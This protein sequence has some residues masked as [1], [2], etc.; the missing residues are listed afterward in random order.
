MRPLGVVVGDPAAD[1][2]AG[3]VE[4]KKD[5]LVEELV[6]HPAVEAF[7]EA[8]LHRF[9]GR[10]VVPFDLMIDCPAEDRVRGELGAVVADNHSWLAARFD[11][12]RQLAGDPFARDRGV[13]DR[14]QTFARHVVN[15]VE[16]AEAPAKGELVVDEVE[17]P[18]CVDLGFA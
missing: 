9:A 15:D 6:A 11:Q 14:R 4:I 12:H 13:G 3:L 5:C 1:E 16:N 8:V 17:R 2:L 18:A 10:D 7:D